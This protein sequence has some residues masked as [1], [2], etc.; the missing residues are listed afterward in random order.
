[1]KFPPNSSCAAHDGTMELYTGTA[2]D[3][4]GI[5]HPYY[6]YA[7]SRHELTERLAVN[8]RFLL[9]TSVHRL[10]PL[11]SSY[12]LNLIPGTEHAETLSTFFAI[13]SSG[14]ERG[15][16]PKLALQA[17]AVANASAIDLVIRDVAES[18]SDT[19]TISAAVS[20]HPDVFPKFA[21]QILKGCQ[22]DSELALACQQVARDLDTEVDDRRRIL[23]TLAWQSVTILALVAVGVTIACLQSE[24]MGAFLSRNAILISLTAVL[25]S[26]QLYRTASTAVGATLITAALLHIPTV[27][28]ALDAYKHRTRGRRQL[29]ISQYRR[30]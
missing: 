28:P 9:T 17:A 26:G 14:L 21:V 29:A 12:W 30:P 24:S 13:V 23:R 6:L 27:A 3:P 10:S 19:C 8:Q 25:I 16:T 2:G 20:D 5:T 22:T 11:K 7:N 15:L 4:Q 18:V 1:M